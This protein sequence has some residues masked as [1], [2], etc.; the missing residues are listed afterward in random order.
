MT[1]IWITQQ[2]P[3]DWKIFIFFFQ[4]E[5]KVTPKNV[6]ITVQLHSFHMTAR[7]CSISFKLGFSS[8]WTENFQIYK[9]GL[10]NTEEPEIKLP[11]Y[12]G[13]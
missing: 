11:T 4:S 8:M 6:Q 10:E 5:R 3:Q 9:M 2:L 13:S 7:L 1:Q 12:S